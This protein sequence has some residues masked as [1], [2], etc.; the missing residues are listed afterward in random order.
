MVFAFWA[1]IPKDLKVEAMTIRA[2]LVERKAE[3]RFSW[4]N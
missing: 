2:V 3:S 4:V 1:Y